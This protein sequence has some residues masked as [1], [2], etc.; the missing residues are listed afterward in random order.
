MYILRAEGSRLDPLLLSLVE[1]VISLNTDKRYA[2]FL[3]CPMRQCFELV[4]ISPLF[5]LVTKCKA[6]ILI[7]SNLL[8][9]VVVL[10]S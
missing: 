10:G 6:G 3:D 8:I 4:M 1:S 2:R 9:R 5:V 7:A